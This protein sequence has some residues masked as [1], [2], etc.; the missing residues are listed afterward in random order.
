MEQIA[1]LIEED[2]DIFDADIYLEPPENAML[3][4]GDSDD[5]D[6]PGDINKLSGNQLRGGAV[7][8]FRKQTDHG[9]QRVQTDEEHYTVSSEES[10][11]D[12]IPPSPI[13]HTSTEQYSIFDRKK[14]CN[15]VLAFEDSPIHTS[16][17][18]STG[19]NIDAPCD[20]AIDVPTDLCSTV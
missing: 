14:P 9:L 7:C 3:S 17:D 2:D 1:S 15:R 11:V 8:S 10:D 6:G 12:I 20:V 18:V 16:T 4:D 5:E 13:P 19:I